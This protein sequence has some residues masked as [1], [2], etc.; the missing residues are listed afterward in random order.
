MLKC[1]K[2]VA[3]RE[4]TQFSLFSLS[5]S[6][7]LSVC[8][9]VSVSVSDLRLKPRFYLLDL[10]SGHV[11]SSSSYLTRLHSVGH[12]TSAKHLLEHR[13]VTGH[14]RAAD[15]LIHERHSCHRELR[16]HR[17]RLQNRW[18]IN[19][20]HR[21][22]GAAKTLTGDWPASVMRTIVNVRGSGYWSSRLIDATICTLVQISRVTWSK[23]FGWWK[24]QRKRM[25]RIE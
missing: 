7:S 15:T 4:C 16:F 18:S 20:S 8:V 3:T 21:W 6:L 23:R 24:W 25:I 12:V 11:L 13:F 19:Q 14:R 22:F 9:S 2:V 10:V 1:G 17:A 5:L